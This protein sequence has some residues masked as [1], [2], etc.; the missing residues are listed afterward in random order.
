MANKDV[1]NMGQKVRV[2]S[3][4][5]LG[6]IGNITYKRELGANPDNWDYRVEYTTGEVHWHYGAKLDRG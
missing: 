6:A 4:P 5:H 3:G 2:L 1:F